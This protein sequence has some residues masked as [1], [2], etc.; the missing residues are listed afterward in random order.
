MLHF[1]VGKELR[2]NSKDEEKQI[3]WT[4]KELC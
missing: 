2:E 3:E 4:F 1:D